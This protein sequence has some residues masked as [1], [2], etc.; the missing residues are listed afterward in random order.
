MDSVLSLYAPQ[1]ASLKISILRKYDPR[2]TVPW[3]AI[4][5]PPGHCKYSWSN[6]IEASK[7]GDKIAVR[8]SRSRDWRSWQREGVRLLIA[9]QGRGI[10]GDLRNRVFDAFFTTKGI[11]GSGLGLWLSLGIIHKHGGHAHLRSSVV[12]GRSG[13]CFSIFL[14]AR[15]YEGTRRKSRLI[16]DTGLLNLP[17]GRVLACVDGNPMLAS[18]VTVA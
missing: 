18:I 6:A 10:P 5:P 15:P 2:L 3:T 17:I 4:G 9:D 14:P 8:V 16:P 13:T 12:L 1:L 7:P 11:K